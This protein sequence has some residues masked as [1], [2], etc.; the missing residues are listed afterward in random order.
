MYG[1]R[2]WSKYTPI[3]RLGGKKTFVGELGYDY[4]M[5]YKPDPSLQGGK[6]ILDAFWIKYDLL[7]QILAPV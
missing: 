4:K 3:N 6:D 2:M 5:T 7:Y 1:T